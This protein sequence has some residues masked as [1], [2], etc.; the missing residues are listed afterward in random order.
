MCAD[1]DRTTAGERAQ[2]QAVTIGADDVAEILRTMGEHRVR[3]LSVIDGHDFVG[4]MAVP[5]VDRSLPEHPAGY[6]VEAISERARL[7][8]R[9]PPGWA[10]D[11]VGRRGLGCCQAGGAGLEPS[12]TAAGARG[13]VSPRRMVR[14]RSPRPRRR[15]SARKWPR[16][17]RNTG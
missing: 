13:R 11:R 16:G 4:I 7:D 9:D 6:L 3:R 17:E 2:G 15:A 10:L 5:V 12:V 14:I 1:A 8:E